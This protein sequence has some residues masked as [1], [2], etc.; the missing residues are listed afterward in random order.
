VVA[1]AAPH[2]V[3]VFD[4]GFAQVAPTLERFF[5]EALLPKGEKSLLQLVAA[6]RPKA[7]A[8]IDASHFQKGITILSEVL[9]DAP[10]APDAMWPQLE[11]SRE[12]GPAFVL[13]GF[14]HWKLQDDVRAREH[15]A[16]GLAWGEYLGAANLL[17]LDLK[18]GLFAEAIAFATKVLEHRK[19]IP[20]EQLRVI[21]ARLV[22]ALWRSGDWAG[23]DAALESARKQWTES[24]ERKALRSSVA[25]WFEDDPAVL[26]RLGQ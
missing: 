17:V 25:S 4:E 9:T 14:C 11:L 19:R 20:S 2:P 1:L 10:R 16:N 5:D 24:A 21:Q 26:K 3:A 8:A 13:L 12:L 6:A 18:A 23:G 15:Y 7:R 22:V